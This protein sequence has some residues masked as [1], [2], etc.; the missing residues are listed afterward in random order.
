MKVNLI[1]FVSLIILE[2]SQESPDNNLTSVTS[3]IKELPYLGTLHLKSELPFSLTYSF[4]YMDLTKIPENKKSYYY[5]KVEN[6]FFSSFRTFQ[7]LYSNDKVIDN[8]TF[9]KLDYYSFESTTTPTSSKEEANYKIKKP[10]EE[11]KFLIISL[12]FEGEI[13]IK[14]EKEEDTSSKT[15]LIIVIVVVS[16]FIIIVIVVIICCLK[17]VAKR[18]RN[19]NIGMHVGMGVN[20]GAYAVTYPQPLYAQSY[21]QQQQY[22]ESVQYVQVQ[23][24]QGQQQQYQQYQQQQQYQQYQQQQQYGQN[25]NN[26]QQNVY[27]KPLGSENELSYDNKNYETPAPAQGYQS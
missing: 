8:V 17:Q 6:D 3:S 12:I 5:F 22:V 25:V 18:V 26:N 24:A 10:E 20:T 4:I 9:K 21:P 11:N 7:Y 2:L 13:I 23:Q 19:N 16:V 14:S 15:V 1:I 27:M